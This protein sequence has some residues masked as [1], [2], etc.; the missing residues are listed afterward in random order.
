MR[1]VEQSFLLLSG[2]LAVIRSS[3]GTRETKHFYSKQ[4][5]TCSHTCEGLMEAELLPCVFK[6]QRNLI[7]LSIS[8]SR[9]L[10]S[11]VTPTV[12]G[13]HKRSPL[14]RR[15]SLGFWNTS[16]AELKAHMDISG[17]FSLLL[18]PLAFLR[19][20]RLVVISVW[21]PIRAAKGPSGVHRVCVSA[22]YITSATDIKQGHLAAFIVSLIFSF[23]EYTS[24]QNATF[25]VKTRNTVDGLMV[26]VTVLNSPENSK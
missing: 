13:G 17:R 20:C 21:R 7:N 3:R 1:Q 12:S 9:K 4:G 6:I 18:I 24:D 22:S 2:F 23:D 19:C 26:S 16:G 8:L 25:T 10:R 11:Y 14:T 15:L 5:W